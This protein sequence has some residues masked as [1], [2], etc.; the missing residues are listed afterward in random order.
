MTVQ[1]LRIWSVGEQHNFAA[2]SM[3]VGD[4]LEFIAVKR[5]FKVSIFDEVGKM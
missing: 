1:H 2:T 4:Y 5:T 3:E